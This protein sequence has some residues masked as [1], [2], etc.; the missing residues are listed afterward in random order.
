MNTARDIM[1]TEFSSLLPTTPLIDSIK[2]FQQN[3]E[4]DARRVF[5]FMVINP[6]GDL[7][8]IL[9]MEDILLFAQPKHSHIWGEMSD[10]DLNGMVEKVCERTRKMQ[11]GDIMSTGIVTVD[12]NTNVFAVLAKMNQNRIRRIPVVEGQKVVGIIYLS[13]LFFYLL[14]Q[15]GE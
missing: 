9:S 8:G 10:I 4:S 6:A 7:V 11:V 15:L 1:N 3:A 13:D 5:G 12:V 14:G 2:L